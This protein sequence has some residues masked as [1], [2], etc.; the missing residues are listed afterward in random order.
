MN[1]AENANSYVGIWQSGFDD[2]R[3]FITTAKIFTF[4]YYHQVH[5]F[6]TFLFFLEA[7]NQFFDLRFPFGYKDVFGAGGDSV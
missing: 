7:M 1:V 5:E 3:H 4:S 6:F 2:F